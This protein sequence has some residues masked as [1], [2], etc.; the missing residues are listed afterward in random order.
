LLH[1]VL[2]FQRSCLWPT[3]RPPLELGFCCVGFFA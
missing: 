1:I 2:W 3:S